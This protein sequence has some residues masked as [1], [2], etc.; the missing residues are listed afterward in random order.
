MW[1]DIEKVIVVVLGPVTVAKGLG[2]SFFSILHEAG[3]LLPTAL[4]T[5][6]AL[7]VL[8]VNIL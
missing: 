3:L 6:P 1:Y 4:A 7:Q 8:T 5:R 2:L